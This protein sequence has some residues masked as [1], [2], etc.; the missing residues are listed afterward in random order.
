MSKYS[1]FSIRITDRIKGENS[2]LHQ[3]ESINN[4][5]PNDSIKFYFPRKPFFMGD[6]LK[7]HSNG[8]KVNAFISDNLRILDEP[9]LFEQMH[10]GAVYRL[11]L[12][13]YKK[14]PVVIRMQ[15]HIDSTILLTKVAG[16][17]TPGPLKTAIIDTCFSVNNL[18]WDKFNRGIEK[19]FFFKISDSII[20]TPRNL[21]DDFW[22]LEWSKAEKYHFIIWYSPPNNK[23]IKSCKYLISISR[24]NIRRD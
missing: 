20:D 22:V 21:H 1:V 5:K 9:V 15:R 18:Q 19:S 7:H 3:P 10:D 2:S 6:S 16:G 17:Y 23:L 13:R 4:T 12:V 8:D 24:Y 14:H 11:T